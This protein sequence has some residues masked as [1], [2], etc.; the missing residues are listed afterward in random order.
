MGR[1][2]E[3]M[4]RDLVDVA[5]KIEEDIQYQDVRVQATRAANKQLVKLLVP[6]V[7]KAPKQINGFQDMMAAL[8][9]LSQGEEP[10]VQNN[11][12]VSDEVRNQRLSV[13]EQLD[14]GLLED[15][16]VDRKS[17]V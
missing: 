7:K 2:V 3:S 16:E 6:G 11:E 14:K 10:A 5:V 1:D 9:S 12:E 4:I 13:K 8:N 17:V 15:E